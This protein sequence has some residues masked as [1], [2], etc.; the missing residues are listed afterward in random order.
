MPPQFIPNV[1]SQIDRA[2]Q[3]YFLANQANPQPIIA[4][5][6]NGG[7]FLT[8]DNSDRSNPCRT[9]F[10]HDAQESVKFSGSQEFT[11]LITDQFEAL[12]QPGQSNPGF[13]RVSIDLQVGIMMALMMQSADG[14]DLDATMRN[15]TDA[16]R[17]LAVFGAGGL[18]QTAQIAQNNADMATF[19]C[20][21]VEPFGQKRGHPTNDEGIADRTHWV[22]QRS[23]RIT[24]APSLILG[25]SNNPAN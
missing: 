21:F 10:A 22:E 2:L 12:V 4:P 5:T 16:G 13:N 3:A 9:I 14:D 11:V 1:G 25:Y 18:A 15:I 17:A 19:T 23:F 8:L 20:M 6:Y 7:I 24:A